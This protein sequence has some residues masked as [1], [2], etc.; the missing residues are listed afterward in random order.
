MN[1]LVVSNLYPPDCVGGYEIG[2]RDVVDGL[3]RRGHIVNVLCRR[4]PTKIMTEE[5]GVMRRLQPCWPLPGPLPARMARL[6]MRIRKNAQILREICVR[7]KTDM[8]YVWNLNGIPLPL[9]HS[10]QETGLPLAWY[11]FDDWIANWESDPWFQFFRHP[12]RG[13]FRRTGK[14]LLRRMAGHFPDLSPETPRWRGKFQFASSWL[15]QIT[16]NHWPQAAFDAEIVP[17]GVSPTL[18]SFRNED[19]VPSR[20]LYVGQLVP[21]KG[22]HVAIAAFAELLRRHPDK[23]LHLTLCGDSTNS[24]YKASLR[25]MAGHL[26]PDTVTFSGFQPRQQLGELYRRHD[27]LLFTSQWEEPFGIVP[28]EAMASGTLVV[29]TGT[30]GSADYLQDGINCLLFPKTDAI[31]C[32]DAVSRLFREPDLAGLLRRQARKDI[33]DTYSL[34][35]VFTRIETSLGTHWRAAAGR[36]EK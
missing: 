4:P 10:L 32:A 25:E 35:T 26:P 13:L 28:L 6:A 8:I 27:I 22:P 29:A 11:V 34:D 12:A 36:H 17:F 19:R 23:P 31:A 24:A 3:R 21:H 16:M 18:F 5:E 1:I 2:C 7:Q 14:E 33:T 30:G 20:L 15:Q 9:L